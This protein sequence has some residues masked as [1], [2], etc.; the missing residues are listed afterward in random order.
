MTQKYTQKHI[1]NMFDTTDKKK[2]IKTKTWHNVGSHRNNTTLNTNFSSA[3][4]Y[5][6]GNIMEA[7][8]D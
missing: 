3:V 1:V 5:D 6:S 2:K 4:P 8:P 7:T